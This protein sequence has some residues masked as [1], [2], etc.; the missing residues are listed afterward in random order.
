[1]LKHYFLVAWRSIVRNKFYSF[2]LTLGLALGIAS[3]LMLGMYTWHELTYDNFHE[4]KDRIF[5]VGVDAKEGTEEYKDGTT[6]PPTGPALLQHFPE[7][8]NFTRLAFWFDDVV[9]S[10]NDGSPLTVRQKFA[11]SGIVGADS[12]IFKIFTI[13]FLA[14]NPETALT[15]PNSIV[16]TKEIA[17]KYFG[18]ED[19]L[20]QTLHF[21][22]FIANC[23]VTGIV[24]NYPD[25]SHF[26]FGILLSLSS[27]ETINFDFDN[28]WG[29][30]TFSTYVL[31]NPN[32]SAVDIESKLQQFIKKELDPYLI[33]RYQKSY[34]EM[35]KGGDHYNL[36]LAPLTEIHLSTLVHENQEG[37]K[38]LV[39]AL[40]LI[41]LMIIILVCINYTNL[42]T[43]LSFSRAREVGIRKASGS[44]SNTLFKQFLTESVIL[45]FAGLFLGLGLVEFFTPFFNNLTKQSL[46]LDYLNAFVASG[47]IVF[48]LFIA[49][50][51]GFYP[52]LTFASFNPI[53]ALKGSASVTGN[54]RQWLRNGLIIFQFTVCII[55]TVSTIVVYKQLSYMTN[56][57]LGFAKDQVVVVK[58]VE[59]LKANK[60]VFKNELKKALGILSVSYTETIPGRNFNGHTQHL[61]GRPVTE[62]PVIYPFFADE[63]ILETLDIELI[64]GRSFKDV[65]GK[66]SAAILNETAV[67]LLGL[68]N[69]L[70]EKI[71]KGTM[72]PQI[73]DIIG[74]VKDFHFRS[75]HHRIEPLVFFPLDVENDPHH[76]TTFMLVK[77][78][79]SNI[80]AALNNIEEQWKIFAGNYPFEYSFMDE[81]FNKL[82]ERERT[83]VRVYT[84]FSAI[85]ISIAC[86][87]LLGLTSYFANKRAKEIGIRK[88][89]GASMANIAIL[90]SRQ[91]MNWLVISIIIGSSLSWYLMRLW[92]ENFAYQTQM[93]SWIFILSGVSVVIIAM[94]AVSWHLYQAAS[95]NPVE[96][97]R[98]E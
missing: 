73:I 10:R 37:K 89:V 6:T 65:E 19:P 55:M 68:E 67:N 47:L 61:A 25:N 44:R 43:V 8:E 76:N 71:D 24:E 94:I 30:H 34:D 42:A 20:G 48:T 95:R 29:N 98:Y 27:L 4:K 21:D 59:G 26:D 81:D 5:L 91:F 92:L 41:G 56:K 78:N 58:R 45:A 32:S 87:G 80:P 79:S 84:I 39:Y 38:T 12:S 13:P 7:I 16:V 57:N 97:L 72:G 82:F 31:L 23:K 52:A 62:T 88:I 15:Q 3:S 74:V 96:T 60:T 40:G 18:D 51:A 63:D 53:R 33:Q 90:L 70:E 35:Y 49:L 17:H 64:L 46:H 36:F 50:L 83:M 11:E 75:F 28:S 85:S 77:V 54:N 1:M 22:H 86:L 66:G 9:V 93:H 14:G 2:I 69:A